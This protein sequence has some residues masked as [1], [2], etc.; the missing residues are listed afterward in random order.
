M[1]PKKLI[2]RSLHICVGFNP[3]F[4]YLE[5]AHAILWFL[6]KKFSANISAFHFVTEIDKMI[7][8][9]LRFEWTSKDH[10][11]QPPCQTGSSRACCT[12]KQDNYR[13]QSLRSFSQSFEHWISLLCS[14][15]KWYLNTKT[16]NQAIV[17]SRNHKP[18]YFLCISTVFLSSS[19]CHQNNIVLLINLD[20]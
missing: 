20:F 17:F 16:S 11:V 14:V 4:K 7:T 3:S 13:K 2:F 8:E 19:T 6:E 18:T 5:T 9:W 15:L 10:L 12:G 1:N